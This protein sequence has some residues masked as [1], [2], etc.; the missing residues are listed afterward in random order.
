MP[1]RNA[2]AKRGFHIEATARGVARL[3]PGRGTRAPSSVARRHAAR[4]RA[5]LRE[6]FAGRRAYF[7]VP[8]DLSGLPAFQS[9]VLAQALRVD[10][11]DVVS[12][13]T[14][15]RRVGRPR[16]AR[17]VGNA[18]ATNPVP[19]FVPCHRVV[20]ADGTWGPYAFGGW[21]KTALL[22]LERTAPLIGASTTRVVCRLGCPAARRI[23]RAH[24]VAFATLADARRAGYRPCRRCLAT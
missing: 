12:Y 13:T 19:I 3:F 16:A 4:A 15:A 18:L 17:A 10:F 9:R 5:Q 7:S 21:M 2:M 22:D 23:R 6:Y 24:R 8:L 1:N 20:R 14:L 11:G